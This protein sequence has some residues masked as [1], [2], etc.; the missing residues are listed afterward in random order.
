MAFV[1][2]ILG[3]TTLSFAQLE[4]DLLSTELFVGFD[5]VAHT[6]FYLGFTFLLS[7][8]FVEYKRAELTIK[9]LIVIGLIAAS[10]GLLIEYL[11]QELTS[12][13]QAEFYDILANLTGTLVAV[14]FLNYSSWYYRHLN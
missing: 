12:S 1:V 7:L 9:Q 5:K 10:Y 8:G 2:W 6:V 3:I 11:Q 14:L 13:R 4:N